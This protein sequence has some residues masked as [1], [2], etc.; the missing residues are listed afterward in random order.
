MTKETVSEKTIP[1]EDRMNDSDAEVKEIVLLFRRVL[2]NISTN[3]S[4]NAQVF[5]EYPQELRDLWYFI[6]R[7]CDT[8]DLT[9]TPEWMILKS[10]IQYLHQNKNQKVFYLFSD[11]I[12]FATHI[13]NNNSAILEV[14]DIFFE[15]YIFPQLASIFPQLTPEKPDVLKTHL[16]ELKSIITSYAVN[17][18]KFKADEEGEKY[19]IRCK[20]LSQDIARLNSGKKDMVLF[21]EN[22]YTYK[23]ETESQKNPLSL[24]L[25]PKEIYSAVQQTAK[26]TTNLETGIKLLDHNFGG[27]DNPGFRPGQIIVFGGS[28][29]HNKTT[30]A[31]IIFTKIVSKHKGVYY[32]CD[33]PFIEL[34]HSL[35]QAAAEKRMHINEFERRFL[36]PSTSIEDIEEYNNL[37]KEKCPYTMH[38]HP[39]V[40]LMTKAS[41]KYSLKEVIEIMNTIPDLK[42]IVIDYAQILREILDAREDKTAVFEQSIA[43][44]KEIAFEKN[45]TVLL[46]TQLTNPPTWN[47]ENCL[48]GDA[49]SG[50]NYK[51]CRALLD[52]ASGGFDVHRP[53]ISISYLLKNKL[54]KLDRKVLKIA[55]YMFE[56]C[57]R[58][59]INKSRLASSVQP[60]VFYYIGSFKAERLYH[61][62][63]NMLNDI[64]ELLETQDDTLVEM[65]KKVESFEK[66]I[67][68]LDSQEKRSGLGI[69]LRN[70]WSDKQED[71]LFQKEG[72][73]IDKYKK[74]VTNKNKNSWKN[75]KFNFTAKTSLD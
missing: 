65:W 39:S 5:N 7:H 58:L 64:G 3:C 26:E 59:R 62:N 49:N 51:L 60:D 53:T 9:K 52:R 4:K 8:D 66:E 14:W 41:L 27:N 28:S 36:S 29:R 1:S 56:D 61:F 13:K 16:F 71:L 69:E 30:V 12:D 38:V 34:D 2:I 67:G 24:R 25:S 54:E 11:A 57:I 46:L 42:F 43:D 68:N 70:K 17:I 6:S 48:T 50:T 73:A 15:E 31:S 21:F 20:V 44:L 63:E 37:L 55:L 47:Q 40:L 32:S 74:L 33:Q 72:M 45:I 22:L 19:L 18:L 75:K 35:Y 10:V 23:E